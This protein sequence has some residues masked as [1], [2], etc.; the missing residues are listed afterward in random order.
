MVKIYA[1]YRIRNTCLRWEVPK[2][3]LELKLG[4]L[5]KIIRDNSNGG[6]IVVLIVTSSG[7]IMFVLAV[8]LAIIV[9]ALSM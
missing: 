9:V 4:A 3:L 8:M 7:S 1:T 2:A 6:K 5:K